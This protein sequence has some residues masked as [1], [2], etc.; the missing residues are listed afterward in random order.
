VH[1]LLKGSN[2]EAKSNPLALQITGKT[3]LF[4]YFVFYIYADDYGRLRK[5]AT[6]ARI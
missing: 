5:L 4:N 1:L 6:T 2:K 3:A